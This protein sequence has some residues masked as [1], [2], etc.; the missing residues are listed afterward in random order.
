[1]ARICKACRVEDCADCSNWFH[2]SVTCDHRCH[3]V[4][5]QMLLPLVTDGSWSAD[6]SQ[7]GVGTPPSSH[8]EEG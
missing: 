7:R 5:V 4:P 2:R 3:I 6:S 8:P 1:M